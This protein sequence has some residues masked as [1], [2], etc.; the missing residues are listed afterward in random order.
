LQPYFEGKYKKGDLPKAEYVCA[1]HVC[2]PLYQKMTT[3]DAE[4]V[5]SSVRQALSAM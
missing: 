4:Y 1:H 5:V 2:M 3:E